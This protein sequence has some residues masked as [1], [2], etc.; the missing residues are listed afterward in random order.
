MLKECDDRSS[1]DRDVLEQPVTITLNL[2]NK[3]GDAHSRSQR[4]GK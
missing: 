4:S 1:I 3:H 2:A